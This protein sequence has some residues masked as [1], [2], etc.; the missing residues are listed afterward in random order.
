VNDIYLLLEDILADKEILSAKIIY[1]TVKETRNSL[2]SVID[3]ILI[4]IDGKN[5]VKVY[6]VWVPNL[7]LLKQEIEEI[8][9]SHCFMKRNTSCISAADHI[10]I[11]VH[12]D[13]IDFLFIKYVFNNDKLIIKQ[14]GYQLYLHNE[15][16]PSIIYYNGFNNIVSEEYYLYNKKVASSLEEF[17]NY[18]LLR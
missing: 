3:H 10:L 12:E 8:N 13:I 17:Q 5:K 15:V 1:S 18:K 11:E 14:I 4:E 2:H 9:I 6:N 16:I 7:F